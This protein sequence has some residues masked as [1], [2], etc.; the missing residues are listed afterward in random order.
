MFSFNFCN[1]RVSTFKADCSRRYM[2]LI[3]KAVCWYILAYTVFWY[4]ATVANDKI[5]LISGSHSGVA[6][7]TSL[8]GC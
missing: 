4:V 1:P 7:D 6:E 2:S 8:L 5:Y 3:R